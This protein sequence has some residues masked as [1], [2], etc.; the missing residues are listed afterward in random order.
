MLKQNTR[1]LSPCSVNKQCVYNK[2]ELFIYCLMNLSSVFD[3][4]IAT[5]IIALTEKQLQVQITFLENLKYHAH[6]LLVPCYTF[7][8]KFM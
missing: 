3:I 7:Q 8:Y 2:E 4:D 5:E 6:V 1:R